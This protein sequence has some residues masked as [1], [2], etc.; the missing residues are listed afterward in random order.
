VR[1]AGLEEQVV[2]LGEDYRRLRGVYD[3]LVSV[4]MIEA[5]GD[6]YF[7]AYFSVCNNLLKPDGMMLLQAITIAD[8]S[9]E[10]YR[11]SVD[12][13]QRYV[14]PGGFLPSIEAI[15][16]SLT[17]STDFRLFHLEDI[18]PHYAR[19]LELWRRR[20][21]GNLAEIRQLGLPEDLLR[22][23]DFYFCYCEGG[24]RE[25][26]IGTVQMLLTRSQCRRDAITPRL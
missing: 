11:R 25:R 13:I 6:R 1:E 21:H 8:Q 20:F 22:I 12:F 9:Y 16:R 5:V 19:T 14:F 2:V 17:R 18:T 15:S 24:F 23:W 26:V 10:T 7:D 3:K 4:E